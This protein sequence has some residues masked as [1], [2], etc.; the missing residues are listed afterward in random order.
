MQVLLL[1][2]QKLHIYRAT[3]GENISKFKIKN[4]ELK[5]FYNT[6]IDVKLV[7][8]TFK[9]FKIYKTLQVITLL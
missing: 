6:V 2:D 7:C 4:Q 1:F 9:L 3:G 8:S 5:N